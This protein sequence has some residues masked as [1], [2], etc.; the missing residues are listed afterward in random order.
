MNLITVTERELVVEPRGLDKMWSFTRRLAIPL[1][2][3][4]G[5][6]HASGMNRE[7]KG[8]RAPGLHLPGKWAGTFTRDGERAFWNVSDNDRTIVIELTDEH[9]ARLVLTVDDPAS[10]VDLING[11]LKDA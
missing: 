4:R 5:A 8:I 2:H 10:A 6:T 7:P 11:A 9:Y 1:A 3:V